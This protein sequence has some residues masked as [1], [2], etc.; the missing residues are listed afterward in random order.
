[1]RKYILAAL[2]A[3]S[4]AAPAMA[5][6]GTDN[7]TPYTGFRVEGL[8]GWD[9]LKVPGDHADGVLYGAGVG[10]DIQTGGL[11]LGVEGEAAGSTTDQCATSVS[12]TGDRLCAKLGRDLYIGG[13]IGAVV[14]GR[15][16]LYAK[17][18]Y[19]NARVRLTYTDGAT[20]VNNFNLGANKDGWRIGGGVE[21]SVGTRTFVKAEYRY[22]T[23]SGNI[24]KHQAVVGFGFRF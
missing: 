18:G 6:P 19:T 4:I 24:D 11:V 2:V 13:R 16:L 9:R 5:Q 3:G 7:P 10:Y 8:V 17:G 23:Y 15:T 14:G 12:V 1:M 20:G 22:S 21:Q